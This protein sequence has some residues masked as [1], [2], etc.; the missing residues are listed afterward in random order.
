MKVRKLSIANKLI[1]GVV[2]LFLVSDIIL[3]AV[4][5]SNSESMLVEQIKA[6][7][8]SVASSIANGMDGAA[9]A[10]LEPG[11]E[12][13]DVYKELSHD[14][15]TYIERAGVEFVYLIR[16]SSNGG[17]E[18]T[19][20]AEI[21]D[22]SMIGDL[23]EDDEAIPALSG[24]AVASSEPYS[25]DWGTHISAYSPIYADGR[26]VAAVG[27]DVSL[28]SIK[29]QTA[30][31]MRKII[32]VCV[33]VLVLG[34]VVLVVISSVLKRKFV[35]LNDKIVELTAGGGDLTRQIELNSG[36][37][38][39]VIASNINKLI[40]YIRT[41]LLSISK[42]SARLNT[43]SSNIA[44]N[45]RGARDEAG[46]ISD[47]MTDMSSTME[48]TAAS[49]NE[50]N[51]LVTGI[52]A[53]FEDIVKEIEGGREFAV[54]IKNSVSEMGRMS[55]MKRGETESMMEEKVRTVTEKIERSKAVSR[56][57]T[58]TGNIIS[59]ANQTN[60]LALN[61]SIEAARAGEAGRGFAVVATEIGDL[62]NNSQAAASEIKSVSG[63]VVT[64]VNELSAEAQDLISFV[65]E[66]TLS[67]LDNLARIG[68]DYLSSAEQVSEMM[69]RFAEFSAQIGRN[70]DQIKESTGVVN[71]AVESAAASV[72]ETAQRSVE[73]SDHMSR[74]D[75]DAA[76]SSEISRDLQTEVVRFKLE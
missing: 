27:V 49:I 32:L 6:N 14:L 47:T 12:E 3:G 28:E 9:I 63:E 19:A 20:D 26:V 65:N 44:D 42:E 39:E 4:I 55:D 1:F 10:A 67:G 56:I 52:N 22:A 40:E 57:E 75:E 45:V 33:I 68:H 69:E 61:A 35:L 48:E 66:T 53:S 71:Q 16:Y 37:E 51:D 74:I 2:L 54:N 24:T 34:V 60:L 7:T 15:T 50:I 5:Y 11:D 46:S 17:I 72:S 73:M 18:Y 38:F 31:L 21:E 58:L 62:A 36:D 43:A 64:V 30:S 59:I 76:A 8:I 25:D 29:Q 23:F 41:M 13:T 70:I